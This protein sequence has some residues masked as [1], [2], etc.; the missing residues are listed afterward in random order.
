MKVLLAMSGGLDSSVAA[1]LLQN[2][3]YEI[4]GATFR[5]WDYISDNCL[6]K[7][8]GCCSIDAIHEAQTFAHNLGFEHY[9]LDLRKEFKDVVIQNFVSE[10]AA[11]RTPNPCVLCNSKIK[12]G[13]MLEKADELGCDY[14]ATGHYAG[15]RKV[16]NRNVLVNATD[17]HKDQTY[18]LWQLTSE[19]L[20]RTLFP[21]YSYTKSQIR[22]KAYQKGFVQ[23]SEK[24]ESQEICFIPDNN[25][26]NF[27][28]NEF[29]EMIKSLKEGDVIDATGRVIGKHKGFL[30]YTIG[31]RKGLGISMGEP[32]YVTH[33]DPQSNTIRLGQKSELLTD[34]LT[35]RNFILNKYT[36]IPKQF[37]ADVKIRYNTQRVQ[38]LIENQGNT[39]SVRF[40]KKVS[41]VTPGQSA[42]FYQE[43]ECIGGGIIQQ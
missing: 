37:E 35:V 4:A 5:S 32:A 7:N 17:S 10:Y 2:Q 3:G 24:R 43:D 26:R 41:A 34:T 27:I 29:P 19:Q 15:I 25:Y 6:A 8:T 9:I 13:L 1:I 42:V 23:L 22:Q 20:G 33:I 30:N 14:I 12:W 21:L 39:L 36:E 31:Q 16:N 11:G 40:E 38:A 28:K 18:F